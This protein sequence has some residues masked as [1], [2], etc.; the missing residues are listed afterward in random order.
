[1][2]L[3]AMLLGKVPE[4]QGHLLQGVEAVTEVVAEKSLT[5]TIQKKIEGITVRL[6]YLGLKKF[7]NFLQQLFGQIVL[8]YDEDEPIDLFEWTCLSIKSANTLKSDVAASQASVKE[9]DEQIRK[10]EE[11]ISEFTTLKKQN[12]DHLLEK[13]ALLL[14]EKKLKV[15]DQQRIIASANIDPSKIEPEEDMD[16]DLEVS[17]GP[18][19]PRKRKAG[20]VVEDD[21]DEDVKM[22]VDEPEVEPDSDEADRQT[23]SE[24]ESDSDTNTMPSS[25]PKVTAKAKPASPKPKAISPPRR[26]TRGSSVQPERKPEDDLDEDGMPPPRALPFQKKPVARQAAP[27]PPPA[28]GSE[29]E[30]ETDEL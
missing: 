28:E 1:M 13:F 24:T 21:S 17:A 26:K 16:V 8:K 29:T 7:A 5:I 19:R 9:R 10:L 15:R 11:T 3:A 4:D 30:S 23:A 6:T 18:S 20:T 14:N 22:E 12:E 2:V 27:L 25:A